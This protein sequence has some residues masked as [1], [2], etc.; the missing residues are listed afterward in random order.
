MH[1]SL[2]AMRPFVISPDKSAMMIPGTGSACRRCF[3]ERE[4]IMDDDLTKNLGDDKFA[5]HSGIRL[6]NVA[7]GYAVAE[8]EIR[9]F[10]LNGVNRV[11]GG[12]IF[13]LADYAFAAASNTEGFITLGI[14]ANISYFKT[15]SG[16]K[17]TAEAREISGQSRISGY[18]VDVLDEDGSLLA[19]VNCMGYVKKRHPN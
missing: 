11:M 19:R 15:P 10:H 3:S 16:K 1:I 12:A 17:I 9:E 4:R 18:S 8:M 5:R 13:T 7:P 2:Y 14:S 6:V